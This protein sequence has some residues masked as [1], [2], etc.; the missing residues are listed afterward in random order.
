MKKRGLK[1]KAKE[2]EGIVTVKILISHPMEPGTRKDKI[3][4][5]LIPAHFIEEVTCK[6]ADKTVY[7][8]YFA[9]A[10]AKNPFISFKTKDAARGGLIE[11]AWKDNQGEFGKTEFVIK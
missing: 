11:A 4:G 10:I 1:G 6:I 9:G 2:R 7:T 3:T 8:A 5:K